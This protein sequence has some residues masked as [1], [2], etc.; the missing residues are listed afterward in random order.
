MSNTKM[1]SSRRRKYNFSERGWCCQINNGN[2]S[3]ENLNLGI[4]HYFMLNGSR[5]LNAWEQFNQFVLS[6]RGGGLWFV[7]LMCN[8]KE[9]LCS[10]GRDIDGLMIMMLKL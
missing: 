6:P 7:L 9:G 8:P 10:S 5:K 3:V 2:V 1:S 4:I